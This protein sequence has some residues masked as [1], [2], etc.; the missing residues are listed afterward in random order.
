MKTTDA[1]Y[2]R[3]LAR[4][5]QSGPV[6]RAQR[7]RMLSPTARRIVL[8]LSTGREL[9]GI[10]AHVMAERQVTPQARTRLPGIDQPGQL[11]A[12]TTCPSTGE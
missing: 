4:R 10:V 6:T 2:V 9:S 1:F 11:V 5:V 3:E 7:D 8:D 12:A